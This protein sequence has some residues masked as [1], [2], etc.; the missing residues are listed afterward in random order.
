MEMASDAIGPNQHR[1]LISQRARSQQL[2]HCNLSPVTC[3]LLVSPAEAP[4]DDS[5][6]NQMIGRSGYAHAY[7]KIQFPFR[8]DVQVNAWKK[9]LLL[10]GDG[11]KAADRSQS[12]IV[13]QAAADHF[14]KVIGNFHIG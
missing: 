2:A 10:I 4:P 6:D 7:S 11:I 13:F 1:L 14:G 8:R 9:L 12:A 5:L 3:P